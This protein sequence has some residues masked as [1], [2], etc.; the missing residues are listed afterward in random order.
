MDASPDKQLTERGCCL[1][2]GLFEEREIGNLAES[3]QPIF[4]GG[5]GARALL[6]LPIVRE[7]AKLAASRLVARGLLVEDAVPVQ[8]IAFNKTAGTN[9]KVAWH[10]DRQF[11]FRVAAETAGCSGACQ[12]DGFP[13]GQPPRDV[14]EGLLAV[15]VHLDDCDAANG[16]LR[17]LPG[18]HRS[19]VLEDDAID[20]WKVRGAE[21]TCL[22]AK[23]DADRKSVV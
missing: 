17:V 7:A 4:A 2:P 19:G 5:A 10:Q 15:R 1:V 9:W 14:L 18:S 16:P 21:E 3:L 20:S 23:G 12:K 8:A 6:R 13:Y 22:A 11:P